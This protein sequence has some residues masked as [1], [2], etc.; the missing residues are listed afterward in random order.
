MSSSATVQGLVREAGERFRLA[1]IAQPRREARLIMQHVMGWTATQFIASEDNQVDDDRVLTFRRLMSE[2]E[3]RRPL[4]HVF[5]H[6]DFFGRSFYSDGRALVPRAD[7]EVLVEASLRLLQPSLAAPQIVDLGTGS[8]CLLL[9]MLAERFR[10]RG[11]GYDVS[12]EALELARRNAQALDLDDRVE[13]R[14]DSWNDA[15]LSAADLVMSNPPYIGSS[16]IP[17]L[18]P[19]VS[20]HDPWLALDGGE[21]GLHAYHEIIPLARDGMKP[22]AVLA[23]EIGHDQGLDVVLMLEAVG[24]A[25][26]TVLQD[27]GGRDRIVTAI[28]VEGDDDDDMPF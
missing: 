23:L 1:G 17:T 6:V 9:S 28:Q 18:E 8:G 24:F 12:P 16:E 19:E 20:E 7:S 2:R 26:V 5:G 10:A 14:L 27:Y 3:Q 4:A 13:W 15:D 25:D 22:G 11:I 21:E